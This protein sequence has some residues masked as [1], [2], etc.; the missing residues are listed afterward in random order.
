[1]KNMGCITTM[2]V[3]AATLTVHAGGSSKP[4]APQVLDL[5]KKNAEKW[6]KYKKLEKEGW[7]FLKQYDK[8]THDDEEYDSYHDDPGAPDVPVQCAGSDDCGHCFEAAR[9]NL[10]NQRF[11]LAKLRRIYVSTM[12]MGKSA[13]AFGDNVSGI[14]GLSGLYWQYKGR[15]PI[16]SRMKSFRATSVAK[17]E[18]IIG[19]LHDALLQVAACE[20]EFY[21]EEDW[22]NRYGFIYYQF[23]ADRYRPDEY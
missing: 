13:I 11:R 19:D 5:F 22:Y 21:G 17:Y 4:V 3:L 10:N 6:Q 8:L 12:R 14:H 18:E 2:I 23:M 1:M 9:E 15:A 16:E 7:D 20:E